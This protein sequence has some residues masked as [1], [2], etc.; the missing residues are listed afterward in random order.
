ML[1]ADDDENV[2]PYMHDGTY[3]C[4]CNTEKVRKTVSVHVMKRILTSYLRLYKVVLSFLQAPQNKRHL[5]LYGV[6][7]EQNLAC[8]RT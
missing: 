8:S 1:Y 4:D 3:C 6:L 7:Y 5:N 2:E